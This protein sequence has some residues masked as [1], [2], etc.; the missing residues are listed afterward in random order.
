[1]V[2]VSRRR[3]RAE[4]L[5]CYRCRALVLAGYDDDVAGLL[6][7]VDAVTVDAVTEMTALLGGRST[8]TLDDG[9][10]QRRRHYDIAARRHE[11]V[12]VEHACGQVVAGAALTQR[13]APV[14]IPPSSD[15]PPY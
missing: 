4:R 5:H 10:L 14:A 12:L 3:R 15:D 2:L 11:V 9:R 13:S 7:Y 6:T 1:V 8:Y